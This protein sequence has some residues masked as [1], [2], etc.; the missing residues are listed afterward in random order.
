MQLL[1]KGTSVYAKQLAISLGISESKIHYHLAQ[2]REAGLIEFEGVRSIKQ[3]RA[4]LL[5]SVGNEF[6]LS[7][8]S[9]STPKTSSVFDMLFVPRFYK[10]GNLDARIIVGSSVPHGKYDAI[11]RDGHLVGELCL[12]LGSNAVI[13]FKKQLTNPVITD[14]E[15]LS[16]NNQKSENMI[17]IG[18]HITN[19]LTALYNPTLF[20]KFGIGFSDNKISSEDKDFSDPS[21]GL[22]A[23]FKHPK[24]IKKWILVLA[25]VRSLGTRAT[26]YSVVN[27]CVD[28]FHDKDEYISI[29]KG[30]SKNNNQIS[31]VKSL[32][33]KGIS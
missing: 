18:G 23:V 2:L 25:G 5:K 26:I 31:G 7:L 30:E 10:S 33:I 15:F 27:D 1:A 9:V 19:E 14:L 16:T 12:Y 29:L 22:I 3:G 17:L 8:T 4:K 24:N 6:T 11:S 28:I 32:L 20:E 21:D 13:D